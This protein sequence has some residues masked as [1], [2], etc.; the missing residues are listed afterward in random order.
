[1]CTKTDSYFFMHADWRE[2]HKFW[3]VFVHWFT[4]LYQHTKFLTAARRRR[5]CFRRS[6][7][8]SAHLGGSGGVHRGR[9]SWLSRPRAATPPQPECPPK[10]ENKIKLVSSRF[11]NSI[12]K[13]VYNEANDRSIADKTLCHFHFRIRLSSPTTTES[14]AL[15]TAL[16]LLKYI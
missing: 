12:V 1:M 8:G 3:C 7:R 9:R 6:W 11:P 15:Q 13:K 5:C 10:P 2:T 4:L 16:C 14:L